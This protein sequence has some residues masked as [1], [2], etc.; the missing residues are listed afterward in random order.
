[1]LDF[2]LEPVS[3]QKKEPQAVLENRSNGE[4]VQYLNSQTT[5]KLD[6]HQTYW[7]RTF[8]SPSGEQTVLLGTDINGKQYLKWENNKTYIIQDCDA[9]HNI[10]WFSEILSFEIYDKRTQKEKIYRWRQGAWQHDSEESLEFEISNLNK[11]GTF[12]IQYNSHIYGPFTKAHSLVYSL[13]RKHMCLIVQL[14][15]VQ[16]WGFLTNDGLYNIVY[17]YI[18]PVETIPSTI[19]AGPIETNN[20]HTLGIRDGKWYRI[21]IEMESK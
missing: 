14:A 7:Q 19:H 1:M 16:K 6:V 2:W 9:I 5:K 21:N 8:V 20:W 17:D 18:I 13:H 11:D 3:E 15:D 4:C 10:R 12:Q